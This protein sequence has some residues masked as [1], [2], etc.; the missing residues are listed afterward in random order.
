MTNLSCTGQHNCAGQSDTDTQI[1]MSSLLRLL[2][3]PILT[4]WQWQPQTMVHHKHAVAVPPFKSIGSYC[5]MSSDSS[6][7]GVLDGVLA[8]RTASARPSACPPL[9][10]ERRTCLG[11]APPLQHELTLSSSWPSPKKYKNCPPGGLAICWGGWNPFF[12]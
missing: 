5:N 9:R 7:D 6:T 10:H 2:A 4:S 1:I 8:P 12:L 3:Q 11:G